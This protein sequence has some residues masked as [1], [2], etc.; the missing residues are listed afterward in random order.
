MLLLRA[1][2]LNSILRS[3]LW[4]TESGQCLKTLADDDNPIW[5]AACVP[6]PYLCSR[7]L[8]SYI[9]FTPNSRFI[10]VSTQDS[11]VRL[12]N[13]QTSRCVK[14]YT[15]HANRTYCI[16]TCFKSSSKGH[17]YVLGGSEDAKVYIWDLQT[18]EVQQVLEGHRGL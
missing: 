4:D 17:K 7:L 13:T 10:L 12:W 6:L 3:R 9:K 14:T 16:F 2:K 15:G 11:T 18:R 8:S 5:S 1:L